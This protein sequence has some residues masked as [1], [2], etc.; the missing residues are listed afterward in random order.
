MDKFDKEKM[1]FQINDKL[2]HYYKAYLCK[3]DLMFQHIEVYG[4]K[5][6]L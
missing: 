3:E 1:S 5:T 6:R 4:E 2:L